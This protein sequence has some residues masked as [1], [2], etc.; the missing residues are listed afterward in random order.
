MVVVLVVVV[1]V[2]KKAEVVLALRAEVTSHGERE[3]STAETIWTK[4]Q[5]QVCKSF[6]TLTLTHAPPPPTKKNAKPKN[7]PH[8]PD[9]TQ[10]PSPVRIQT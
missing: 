1:L 7:Q 6:V 8:R 2:T 10:K 4:S 5:K 9:P 3:S